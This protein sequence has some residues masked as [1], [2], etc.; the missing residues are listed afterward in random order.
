[1]AFGE[2][3]DFL[4]TTNTLDIEGTVFCLSEARVA[5]ERRRFATEGDQLERVYEGGESPIPTP[6]S[7]RPH[8]N[9]ARDYRVEAIIAAILHNQEREKEV[10]LHIVACIHAIMKK[11]NIPVEDE[12][13]EDD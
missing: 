3:G 11:M 2:Y 10:W 13:S 4:P 6:Q 8:F 9:N 1:M 7:V 5:R 12:H